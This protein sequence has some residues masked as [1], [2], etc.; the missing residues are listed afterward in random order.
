MPNKTF[1]NVDLPAPFSPSRAWTSPLWSVRSTLFSTRARPKVSETLRIASMGGR[2][3]ELV[4]PGIATASIEGDS[5]F[6]GLGNFATLSFVRTAL[7]E[8]TQGGTG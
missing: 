6:V 4:P 5:Q 1:I 8:T 2:N 7:G 3:N